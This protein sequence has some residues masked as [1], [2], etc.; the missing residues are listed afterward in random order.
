MKHLI[1]TIIV[2]GFVSA[3]IAQP[4]KE[5][6][7]ALTPDKVLADLIAGNARFVSGKLNARDI[8]ASVS[9]TAG[10]QYPKAVVLSC[11]DS[12]VPVELVFD[13]GIGDIFV[14]RVAGN[15]AD[16]D[17][18]GSMEFGT[19]LSGAKLVFV[20]GHTACGAVKGVCDG[21]ELGK[22]T[23]LLSK[24]KPAMNAVQGYKP[25]ERTSANTEFVEKV[26]E[27]NVRETIAHVRA[28]SAILADLEKAGTIKI[29]GG[30]YDLKTGK[31]A[32][33]K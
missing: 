26:I 22:L 15:I 11:L 8:K 32:L 14:G 1:S 27:Q 13:Q 33:I 20:L 24:I 9:K 6:Q 2:L 4:T 16:E 30:I 29:V 5:E 21:A 25:E 17:L 7:S 19:K 3:A 28:E 18:I 31:V 12:R 23:G 10:A